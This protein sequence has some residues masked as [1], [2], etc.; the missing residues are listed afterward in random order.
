MRFTSKTLRKAIVDWALAGQP[1]PPLC[2]H[3]REC[4]GCAFQD[5][6]Y[7]DQVA[8][9]A[10]VL[11]ELYASG[12]ISVEGFEVIP[13]PDPFAYRTR[14][15]YV[16]TKGRFG[17]RARGKFNYVIEL[18]TCHLIP[19]AAFA[20][21]QAVWRRAGE[22]GVPDYDIR[23]HTG[24]LRYVVVRRSPSNE[25][26]IAAVTAG[27]GDETTMAALAETALSQPGVA[28]F[29]WLV[30]DTLTDLSFGEP[31]R[32]WGAAELAMRIGEMVCFIGPNTFFQNNIYLAD[33]L[34][35]DAVSAA[36]VEPTMRA[37]DLYGGVG[38]IGLHLARRAASV[39][40]VEAVADSVALGQRNAI[41]NGVANFNP[42]C[43]DTLEYLRAQ[44]EGSLPVIVADPPRTGLGPQVCHELLRIGP[45]RIVYVSCNPLTQVADLQM[46]TT[47]YRV[48]GLRG[49][50]MFPHTPHIEAIAVLERSSG[51]P[52]ETQT[53]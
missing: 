47:A 26:L 27:G 16:A 28:G 50:D 9:K 25:L 6:A 38:A 5:R 53:A 42:I 23:D 37:A 17:L 46:L 49:Y 19:P 4:G 31:R 29:H 2:P 48:I 15:D 35:G 34:I 8:A 1:T 51:E 12:G 40:C 36:A 44:P 22:L 20:A 7:A 52:L 32:H 41:A 11:R 30:N 43:A 18:T 21:A 10:A 45:Q 3:A 14:M 13:S 24:F 33:R 39:D